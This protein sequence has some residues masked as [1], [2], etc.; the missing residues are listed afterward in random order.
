MQM[1]YSKMKLQKKKVANFNMY[2]QK[3]TKRWNNQI[4]A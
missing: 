3:K 1:A 4:M 2:K